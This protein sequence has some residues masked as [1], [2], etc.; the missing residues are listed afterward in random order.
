MSLFLL[1]S[2]SVRVFKRTGNGEMAV[3]DLCANEVFGEISM[4]DDGIRFFSVKSLEDGE[5][6]V[7]SKKQMDEMLRKAPLELFLVLECITQKLKRTSL[8]FIE[9]YEETQK[10][11]TELGKLTSQ[12]KQLETETGSLR[13]KVVEQEAR[14]KKLSPPPAPAPP[15][16]D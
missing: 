2:G 11:K 1:K 3:D 13:K 16:R 15:A 7:F 5:A 6:V 4:F 8:R 12:L 10:M 9:Q 14:I